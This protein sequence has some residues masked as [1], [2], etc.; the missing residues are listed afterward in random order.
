MRKGV[1]RKRR[2]GVR[3]RGGEREGREEGSCGKRRGGVRERRGER[4]GR[5]EGREEG[6]RR[7]R[8]GE[9]GG[10][11]EGSCEEEEGRCEGEE[12]RCE[13]E[14]RGGVRER[15]EVWEIEMKM[16]CVRRWVEEG[17]EERGGDRAGEGKRHVGQG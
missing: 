5:E 7:E 13:G 9:R 4:G 16:S 12:G 1:V 6:K 14:R 15:E 11:E 2:G 10:R 17:E 8:G 3:E